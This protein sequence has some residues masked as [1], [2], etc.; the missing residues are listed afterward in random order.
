MYK[1]ALYYIGLIFL[2]FLLQLTVGEWASIANI[3]PDFVLVAVIL[4]GKSKGVLYGEIFGFL[5]GIIS[6]SIGST[7]LFGLSTLTKTVSGFLSGYMKRIEGKI[8]IFSYYSLI[9]LVILI[10][11]TI[12]YLIYYN[13]AD[14][15]LQFKFIRY[16]FP[17]SF[18]TFFLY[19]I[20]EYIAPKVK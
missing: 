13:T 20:I 19:L 5:L 10:H 17:S 7:L 9:F 15:T 2:I 18:Y 1:K 3:S 11:F 14:Y 8:T 16:I 6:D 12:S 4:V